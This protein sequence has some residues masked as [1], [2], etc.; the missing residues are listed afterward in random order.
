MTVLIV[1]A[2]I[3]GLMAARELRDRHYSVTVVEKSRGVGGRLAT[4]RLGEG[5]ADTGAQ[6][7]TARTGAFQRHVIN[8]QAQGLVFVWSRGWSH[9]AGAPA[10]DGHPRYAAAGGMNA[11]AKALA[12]DL[13]VQF[14]VKISA[15][16]PVRDGWQVTD[17]E[18]RIFPCRA[19]LLAA[20]VPQSLTFLET[21]RTPVPAADLDVLREIRYAPC[22]AGLFRLDRPARF[23]E[24]G[25]VQEPGG[26]VSW[27]ADNQRKGISAGATVITVHGDP[28][29]S[30]SHYNSPESD[31]LAQLQA[32]VRPWL[33]E[34]AVV[35][36]QLKRWRYARPLTAHSERCLL[37]G[38][39]PPLAFA[40]D[41]FGEPRMEGA[42][43]SGLAA[44]EALAQVLR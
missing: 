9:G 27:A 28:E 8:W 14:N 36:A 25:A 24:P 6:F 41:A 44:A 19:V 23:P 30:R 12:Q 1:G 26:P 10:E 17:G 2:G 33:G 22:L 34:A 20:P 37:A 13:T 31:T 32:A 42:A 15:L 39:V 3:A 29:F 38:G 11:L 40:G 35:E 16:S 4:R 43:L 7:F 21:G 5:Q 18:G